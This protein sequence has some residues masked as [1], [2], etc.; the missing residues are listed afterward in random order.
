[1]GR[2]ENRYHTWGTRKKTNLSFIHFLCMSVKSFKAVGEKYEEKKTR[3]RNNN[4]LFKF[5]KMEYKKLRISIK[6]VWQ[7]LFP[8][9][10]FK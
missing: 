3:Q 5:E 9:L 7:F 6:N 2:E 4:L 1:M 8:T 10:Q